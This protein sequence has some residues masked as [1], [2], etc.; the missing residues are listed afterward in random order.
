MFDICDC[1]WLFWSI[2]WYWGLYCW[3]IDAC[4]WPLEAAGFLTP[5]DSRLLPVFFFRIFDD[6]GRLL[7]IEMFET[8]TS[9]LLPWC[10]LMPFWPPP[11]PPVTLV[12]LLLLLFSIIFGFIEWL[13]AWALLPDV[14]FDEAPW[15]P[16]GRCIPLEA[17]C[18]IKLEPFIFPASDIVFFFFA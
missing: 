12:V 8:C 3:F 4:C 6:C 5:A 16:V 1:A 15:V 9:P 7:A 18:I 14:L 2:C 17:W 13:I 10:W 11:K